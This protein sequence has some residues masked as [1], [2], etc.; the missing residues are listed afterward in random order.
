MINQNQRLIELHRQRLY[1]LE[2]KSALYGITTP[3]E[4]EIEI[5]GIRATIQAL[6]TVAQLAT[7]GPVSI[8]DRRDNSQQM[9]TM[10]A[11]VQATV[12]EVSSIKVYVRDALVAMD[13]RVYRVIKFG[14]IF[15]IIAYISLGIIVALQLL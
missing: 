14:L 3:V 12:A 15:G 8:P 7:T 9:H 11:T 4:I 2:E 13:L 10:I 6:E 1:A 5:D